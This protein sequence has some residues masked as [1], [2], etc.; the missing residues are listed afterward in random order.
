MVGIDARMRESSLTLPSSMGTLKSTRMSDALALR[1][2]VPDGQLFHGSPRVLMA[3]GCGRASRSGRAGGVHQALAAGRRA[4][5]NDDQIRDAAAVA[6]LVVVPGDD[7]H[8]GPAERHRRLGIDDRRAAVAPEVG[9]HERLVGD[10]QDALDLPFGGRA[11][12]VV[13]LLGGDRPLELRG[14]VDDAH[15]RRRHAQAE[16]VELALEL[17]D[18]E[19][20]RLAPRRSWSG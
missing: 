15:G 18:H 20:E 12:R 7:L 3:A 16:A 13:E 17:R 6:P 10:A 4:A 5:T 14:E 9:R 19:R 1:I 11:E 2:E 8:Q